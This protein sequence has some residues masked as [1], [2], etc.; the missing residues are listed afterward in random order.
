MDPTKVEGIKNWPR[1]TKVKDV[2]SFLGFC[3][4]YRPFIPSFSKITKPLN[5]LTHKDV[6][7]STASGTKTSHIPTSPPP[8]NSTTQTKKTYHS[9][10]QK[11]HVVIPPFDHHLVEPRQPSPSQTTLTP[12]KQSSLLSPEC[13]IPSTVATRTSAKLKRSS[14][15]LAPSDTEG[16][17]AKMTKLRHS[18]H[19]CT[20]FDDWNL[21]LSRLALRHMHLLTSPFRHLPFRETRKSRRVPRPP[22][23]ESAQWPADRLRPS[24]LIPEVPGV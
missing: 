15:S 16:R 18:S 10:Y 20:R 13:V 24:N 2:R 17:P 3:N 4:F 19:S 14:A 21:D 6:Q 7:R 12:T 23:P 9:P 22:V 8:A 11:F 5:E 1:P